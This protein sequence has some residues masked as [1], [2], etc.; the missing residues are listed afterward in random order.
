VRPPE[1]ISLSWAHR[2][3]LVP[4]QDAFLDR[5]IDVVSIQARIL[6]KYFKETLKLGPSNPLVTS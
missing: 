6:A 5:Q 3:I 2:E 1:L 4:Y